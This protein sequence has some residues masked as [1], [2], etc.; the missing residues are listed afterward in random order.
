M[1]SPQSSWLTC[2]ASTPAPRDQE[3]A[4][5]RG[6]GLRHDSYR[7]LRRRPCHRRHRDRRCPRRGP[8]VAAREPVPEPRHPHGRGH[9]GLPPESG[10]RAYYDKK[11]AQGKTPKEALRALKRMVSDAIY[12]RLKAD[13]ARA[14]AGGPGGQPGNGT[15]AS[16]AGLHPEHRLFGQATP[17]PGVDQAERGP[18][19][20]ARQQ[21]AI[22]IQVLG[23]P[24]AW[25][26]SAAHR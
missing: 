11:I 8:A 18:P 22:D 16:A 2:G 14:G 12:K 10:G 24:S 7:G 26:M 4:G 9:S 13:A 6:P 23:L 21:P 15:D 1:S 25:S 3:E 19:R 5:H 20:P 17:G